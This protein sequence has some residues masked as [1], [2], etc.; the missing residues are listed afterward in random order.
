MLKRV[1]IQNRGFLFRPLSAELYKENESDT[2]TEAMLKFVIDCV[3][4]SAP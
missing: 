2:M 4:T 1:E 3:A